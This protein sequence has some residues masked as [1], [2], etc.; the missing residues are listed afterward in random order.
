MCGKGSV[1]LWIYDNLHDT[2]D[3]SLHV[4]SDID[5]GASSNILNIFTTVQT[6]LFS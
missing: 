1:L 3:D 6:M 5:F 4:K 2:T